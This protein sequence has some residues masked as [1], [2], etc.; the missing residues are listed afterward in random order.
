M[1]AQSSES[2]TLRDIA[3]LLQAV[4]GARSEPL[5][6]TQLIEREAA[7]LRAAHARGEPCTAYLIRGD[8]YRDGAAATDAEVLAAPLSADAARAALVR[9]HWFESA[10]RLAAHAHDVVD[11]RF[12]AACDAIVAGDAAALRALLLAQPSLARQRS[13]FAHH[14]TLLQH[15]AANG[16]ESH[17]QW[18]SPANAVE[19]ARLLLEA[20]AEPDAPCDSYMCSTALTLL[21]TSAHPAR[22]GVQAPLVEL[23]CEWGAQ[24]DGPERDGQPLWS[25]ISAWYPLAVE[26]LVRAGA[27]VDNLL[28]AA[29]VG[30]LPRVRS[31]FDEQGQLLR[32]RALSFGSARVLG[33]ARRPLRP[34]HMLEY[35]VHWACAH[36]R[37]AVVEYLLGKSPDPSVREP[38]WNNTLLESAEYGGDAAIAELVQRYCRQGGEG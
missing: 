7:A 17:R 29:A 4:P 31:Y 18:Q 11:P 28:F 36:R 25:A 1:T 14:Q 8:K 35:A 24:P 23:L 27:T 2:D 13:P 15:V 32:E 12:E 22:A 20:G 19:L 16:I 9:W 3:R 30:D 38:S 33:A 34:E 10:E 37:R 26:A 5:T 21:V 6:V